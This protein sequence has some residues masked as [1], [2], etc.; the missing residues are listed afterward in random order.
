AGRDRSGP[1]RRL[2]DV[3]GDTGNGRIRAILDRFAAENLTISRVRL[4]HGLQPL[5]KCELKGFQEDGAWESLRASFSER[6]VSRWCPS[7]QQPRPAP[8]RGP[9]R[10]SR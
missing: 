6:S 3:N 2:P 9:S 7:W 4:L 1:D 5:C 10:M 8:S